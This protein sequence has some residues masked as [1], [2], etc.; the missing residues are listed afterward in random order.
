MDTYLVHKTQQKISSERYCNM[1]L[2]HVLCA[3]NFKNEEAVVHAGTLDW[4][5]KKRHT[6]L[7]E[8][9]SMCAKCFHTNLTKH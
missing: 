9:R 8:H 1:A 5:Q 3:H 7:V 6:W 4:E 2:I